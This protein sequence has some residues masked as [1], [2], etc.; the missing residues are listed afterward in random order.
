MPEST[1]INYAKILSTIERF[2]F[3]RSDPHSLQKVVVALLLQAVRLIESESNNGEY[4]K[5]VW[6]KP[7]VKKLNVKTITLAGSVSGVERGNP[8]DKNQLPVS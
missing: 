8:G 7:V 5:K 3:D 6:K 2:D 1:Y 4:M